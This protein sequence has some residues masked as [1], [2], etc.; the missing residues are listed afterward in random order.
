MS[1]PVV[2]S[3]GGGRNSTALLLGM[4]ERA[5]RPDLILFA[6]T[7]GE[8]TPTYEHVGR[9]NRWCSEHEFP[10]IEMVREERWSLEEECLREKTMPSIVLGRRSCSDKFKIRPQTRYLVEWQPA[11]D[12]WKRKEK[13]TKLVGFDVDEAHRI[14]DY[15]DRRF[16]VR[17]PLVDWGWG[18]DECKD[19]IKRHGIPEPPKSS[20]F[21]CPEMQ[22]QEI[23]QLRA[24]EPELLQRA[25]AMEANNVAMHSAKGLMRQM[26]WAQALV[27]IDAGEIDKLPK[28]VRRLPCMCIDGQDD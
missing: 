14:K 20:C 15:D 13:V 9:M 8:K 6:D 12:A 18:L 25:L 16:E 17:Y 28:R 7:R 21:Y 10:Q 4:Y 5:Q 2:V 22:W 1:N 24:D 27:H 19:A 23:V 11:I 3:F 26:S